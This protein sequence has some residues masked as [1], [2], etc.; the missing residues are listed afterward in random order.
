MVARERCGLGELGERLRQAREEQGLSLADVEKRT[1]IR[2]ALLDALEHE[3][4]ARLPELVYVRG[5]VRG[6]AGVLGLDAAPLLA[7]LPAQPQEPPISSQQILDEP[8]RH[9]LAESR[10][11]VRV[12]LGLV[13]ALVIAALVWWLVSTYY[14]RMDPLTPFRMALASHTPTP[15]ASPTVSTPAP[16]R[17]EPTDT[18]T[19][20]VEPEPEATATQEPTP[21]ATIR[22][23]ATLAPGRTPTATLTAA[24]PQ[25]EP[26]EVALRVDARTWVQVTVDGEVVLADLLEVGDDQAWSGQESIE[27]IIGNAGG[28]SLTV[29]GEELG[30]LGDEGEVVNAVYGP[31]E[32]S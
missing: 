8:L 13:A 25:G 30:Y 26:V 7:L 11:W 2:T 6:Y 21:L 17:I 23:P 24:A 18:P 3:D 1:H 16:E 22:I 12:L 29:N 20:I 4:F 5:F 31:A 28:A 27:L 15:T 10:I 9:P 32:P 14:L 19:A